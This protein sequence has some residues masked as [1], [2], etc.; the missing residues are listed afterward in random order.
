MSEYTLEA[1]DLELVRGGKQVLKG[2]SF[3][4]KRGEVF[5]LLGGN[6]A[7]KSTTLLSFMGLLKASAGSAKVLGRSAADAPEAVRKNIAYLPESAALYEHLDARENLD[8]FL[9][10]AMQQPSREGLEEALN[11]VN[12][13]KDFRDKPLR[14]YSKG[15]R[16]KVAIALAVLRATPIL[17]LDEPTSGLDPAAVEDFHSL[18]SELSSRGITVLMVTHDLFGA[19]QVAD[20]VGLLSGGLLVKVFESNAEGAIDINAVRDVFHAREAAQ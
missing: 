6:G 10:L 19:C 7:G 16:Q 2:M 11:T 17:L 1:N 15:M 18:I 13:P 12:L 5:A 14:Q 9:S 20:R 3:A 4:L 8:Y